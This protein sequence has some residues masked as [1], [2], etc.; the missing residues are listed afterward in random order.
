MMRILILLVVSMILIQACNTSPKQ[1]SSAKDQVIPVK[2]MAIN[3][4]SSFNSIDVSGMLSTETEA[5]VSFKTDGLIERILVKEG[6]RIKAG[7]LLA[8]LKPVEVEARVQQVKLSLQKAERDYQ[9]ATNL[10]N[11]SVG[12]LEQVENAKTAMDVARQGLQEAAFNQRYSS[13]RAATD[14]FVTRKLAN[15]GELITSGTPV[16]ILNAVAPGNKWIIRTALS[17]VEW[18]MVKEGCRARISIDAFPGIMFSGSVSKR[19]LAADPVTGMFPVEL[20]LDLGIH[21]AAI[22]MFAAVKITPAYTTSG[23]SI[24]YE[25]LL[26]ANGKSGFVFVT[27]DK[28]SVR[29]VEVKIAAIT[30]NTAYVT[31]GLKGHSYIVTSGSPYLADN[32]FIKTIP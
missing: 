5:R 28:K 23:Y 19:A 7:Q 8:S 22:G 13:I 20:Q 18:A 6:D 32:S 30:N 31:H 21:E 29:K 26:E 25:A 10:F 2:L 3:G 15:T 16:L 4:D 9:R 14:G 11:D 17:D 12:T 27:D 1:G 24:P